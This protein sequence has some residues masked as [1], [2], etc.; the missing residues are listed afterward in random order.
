MGQQK[1]PEEIKEDYLESYPR[2]TGRLAY[3]LSNQITFL[4][5]K[6][7]EYREI[8]G[9]DPENIEMVNEVAPYFFWMYERI[10]RHDVISTIARILDPAYSGGN[11]PNASL[12]KLINDLEDHADESLLVEWEHDL[13]KLKEISKKLRNIRNKRL[14]HSDFDV[15]VTHSPDILAGI[16]RKNI[17]DVLEGIRSLANKIQLHFKNSQTAYN[18]VFSPFDGTKALLA[19][20][21]NN[22]EE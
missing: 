9:S 20:I 14:S 21:E 12:A 19:F 13:Q 22:L 5:I 8:Y 1:N 2:E 7:N 10:L 15:H 11:K 16:S 4:H 17:E 6:W 18:Y 3:Y